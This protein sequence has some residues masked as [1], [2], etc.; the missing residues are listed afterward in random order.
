MSNTLRKAAKSAVLI[1]VLTI[2][3]KIIGLFREIIIAACYGAGMQTDAFFVASNICL[4]LF[5]SIGASLSTTFIPMYSELITLRGEKE[6][7]SFASNV[8]NILFVVSL[9]LMLF[10]YRFSPF[11]VKVVAPGFTGETRQLAV[12][13]L[14]I[15]FPMFVFII[16]SNVSTGI[17][18]SRDSFIAPALIGIPYSVIVIISSVLFSKK[19]GIYTL[20][21]ATFLATISQVLIQ[22]PALR[23]KYQYTLCFDLKDKNLRRLG[24]LVLPVLLGTAVQQLNTLVDRMI[25]SGLV[26]GSIS[27]I[28]YSNRL[29]GFVNGVF[30]V[31]VSTVMYPLFSRYA[32][33]EDYT[34]LGKT[35][36]QTLAMV[37]IILLP[38]TVGAILLREEV[39]G[40]VFQRGAFD[41][42]ATSLTAYA[43]AFYALGLAAFG[44]R[45]VL[46]R[47]FYALKD[48]STP[49]INGVIVVGIN[50]AL[51]L[52]FVR[53]LAV[54]GLA[55]ATSVSGWAG[56][57]FLLKKLTKKLPAFKLSSVRRENSKILFA[58]L[59]M[60]LVVWVVK[61]SLN[62]V[63]LY[64]SFLIL[65]LIGALIYLLMLKL[66]KVEGYR[67]FVN[68]TKKIINNRRHVRDNPGFD[69]AEAAATKEMIHK[70]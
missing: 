32:A 30:V 26:E 33:K 13:L 58:S 4:T 16:I 31:A 44:I 14:R 3:S 38:V 17:L 9:V 51:N 59:I 7:N 52:I 12:E 27:A 47:V 41:Q 49:M 54:G 57:L 61:K 45:A 5:S 1:M 65:V 6:A 60:G 22:L 50:I 66:F 70:K 15:L 8:I 24:A 39:V 19:Y 42:Q 62:V 55:L 56:T 35:F 68:E 43:L 36:T 37:M 53:Y 48:T 69:R 29:L 67:F 25:A 23:K 11:I 46:N 10:G 63:S 28:T 18:Q 40:I 21:W 2:I 64:L 34:D 20:A